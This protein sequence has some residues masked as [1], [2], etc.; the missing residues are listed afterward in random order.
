MRLLFWS[1]VA[2]WPNLGEGAVPVGSKA[3]YVSVAEGVS[4][5]AASQTSFKL[6]LVSGCCPPKMTICWLMGSNTVEC[7]N[8]ATGPSW[9]HVGAPTAITVRVAN[10]VRDPELAVMVVDPSPVLEATPFVPVALLMVAT[11]AFDEFHVTELV[12]SCVLPSV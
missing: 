3:E 6:V 7:A 11:A 9:D 12:K 1:Y 5:V 8:R 2:T 4:V 10:P